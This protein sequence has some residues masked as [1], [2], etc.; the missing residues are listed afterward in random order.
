MNNKA[1]LNLIYSDLDFQRCTDFRAAGGCIDLR[2]CAKF[3]VLPLEVEPKSGLAKTG[4]ILGVEEDA[5]ADCDEVGI[6]LA[7][8]P[9][10]GVM[11]NLRVFRLVFIFG[12]ELATPIGL[13]NE[14]DRL[15]LFAFDFN[16][17]F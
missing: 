5:S 14:I 6:L 1:R 7:E 9:G 12:C 15:W 3:E 8:V 2:F 10:V 16:V 4:P 13:F 17:N 11:A